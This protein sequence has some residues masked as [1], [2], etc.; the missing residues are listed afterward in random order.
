MS[1]AVRIPIQP[2]YGSAAELVSYAGL[3][4]KTIR[5]LVDAGKVQGRKVGRRLLIPYEDL[6]RHILSFEDH[7]RD[8]MS[9]AVPQVTLPRRS[10]DARGRL[11]PLSPEEARLRAEEALRA[12]DDVAAMGDEEEQRAT[13]DMLMQALNE[14]PL[15]DRPRFRG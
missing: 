6:D 4:I 7:R 15:S 8:A 10:T 12:L 14:E 13:L 2:R 9:A 1:I 3:S 11:I 5:R